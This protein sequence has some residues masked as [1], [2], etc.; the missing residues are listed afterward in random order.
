M[1]K[2]GLQMV[3]AYAAGAD[4]V[5]HFNEQIALVRAARDAGF[6]SVWV[7][8]HFVAAPLQYL[9]TV[10][11]LGRVAAEAGHMTI[12]PCVLLLPLNH[13]VRVAE[14]FATLDIITGGRLI[15]GVGA[16]YNEREMTALGIDPRT[17]LG[18]Y[19]EFLRVL[20]RLWSG[21][22]VTSEGRHFPLED[23]QLTLRPVQRPHPPIWIGAQGDAAIRRA[24]QLGDSWIAPPGGP[25]E[26]SRRMGIYRAARVETGRPLPEELPARIDVFLAE[27]NRQA[28]DD[29]RACLEAT[30]QAFAQW[31]LARVSP[32]KET[33][34][35]SYE[36]W[37]RERLIV[38]DPDYCLDRLAAYRAAG[39]NH[40]ILRVYF[41][42]INPDHAHRSIRLLGTHVLPNVK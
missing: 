2:F 17:R 20:P 36:E 9:Q 22:A 26:L 1:I 37:A 14:E 41:P 4:A 25:T 5:A 7:A 34:G 30:D 3:P 38:G 33:A 15:L 24:A 19:T 31:G 6:A 11:T 35:K 16:G 40:F 21:E 32:D 28:L 23:V 12:G 18:R 8:Q 29:A 13:P 42:G 27:T 10:P 39:N